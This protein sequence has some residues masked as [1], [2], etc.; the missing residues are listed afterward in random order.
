M[1]ILIVVPLAKVPEP[2]LVKVVEPQAP[3][4]RVEEARVG[5]L[6]GDDVCELS[7]VR[8][9]IPLLASCSR[10]RGLGGTYIEPEEEKVAEADLVARVADDD[11]EEEDD[12]YGVACRGGVDRVPAVVRHRGGCMGIL[13]GE[14]A[15]GKDAA[16]TGVRQAAPAWL[17]WYP[18]GGKS[19]RSK[20]SAPRTGRPSERSSG[21]VVRVPVRRRSSI[22][23]S[24][25]LP[26]KQE[27]ERQGRGWWKRNSPTRRMNPGPHPPTNGRLAK[28]GTICLTRKTGPVWCPE[29][30]DESSRGEGR[31][32]AGSSDQAQG[33]PIEKT[34]TLSR[35]PGEKTE[36]QTTMD[37]NGGGRGC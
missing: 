14:D 2:D 6:G 4:D 34:K 15:G 5:R 17:W 12:G 24:E 23:E 37:K 7:R 36:A 11:E 32:R 20:A 9:G 18:R 33:A 26:R 19:S 25:S 28:T 22:F 30:S 29:S 13:L 1:D 21:G 3:G 16:R 10:E 35:P 27:A 8:I 31:M